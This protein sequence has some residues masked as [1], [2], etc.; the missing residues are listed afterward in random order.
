MNYLINIH[1]LVHK[2]LIINLNTE[3]QAVIQAVIHRLELNCM[4]STSFGTK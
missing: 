4:E 2:S 3:I 1:Q